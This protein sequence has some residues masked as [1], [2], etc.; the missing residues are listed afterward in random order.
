MPRRRGVNLRRHTNNN[1]D[2]AN[3]G[4]RQAAAPARDQSLL[5]FDGK[6]CIGVPANSPYKTLD[7]V[8]QAAKTK[9]IK[10][11]A[12]KIDLTRW[13]TQKFPMSKIQEALDAA[14]NKESIK[15]ICYPD[16]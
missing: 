2:T 8:V 9:N 5:L 13:V 10:D 12:T 14:N 11:M 4:A 6:G 1:H 16:W 7:E 15:V 3:R